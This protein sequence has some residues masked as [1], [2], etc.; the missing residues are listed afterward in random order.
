MFFF[1]FI[2]RL[3]FPVLY[4]ISGVLYFVTYKLL[5]YRK[6][7]VFNNL[8]NSFPEK[9]EKE[10]KVIADGFYLHL[11]D[12]VVESIK[13]LTISQNDIQKRLTI[14]GI[15]EPLKYLENGQSIITLTGHTGNWEWLLQACQLSSPFKA[16]AVYKPLSSPFFD[17]LMLKIRTRFGAQLLPMT[18]VPRFVLGNKNET[19]VLAMVADQTPLKSEIQFVNT[20]LNQ[21][22]PWF[23]GGE[24]IAQLAETPVFY[25][26]M[27]KLKRGFYEVFFEK[28][29]DKAQKEKDHYPVI[30]SFSKRLEQ[31]IHQNPSFWLW[32]HRRWKHKV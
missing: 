15:D 23:V 25:V 14:K 8:R 11:C 29:S 1:K 5:G 9:S 13:L 2:S 22:T 16:Q 27:N 12:L 17:N 18:K 26:G 32:S 31:N 10:I 30:D 28:I 21:R 19:W 3:P 6:K 7:V 4:F 24:K 20:F